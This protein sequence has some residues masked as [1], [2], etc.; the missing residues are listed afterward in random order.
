MQI[1]CRIS[2]PEHYIPKARY[3]LEMLLY[4]LGLEPAWTDDPNVDLH[5]GPDAAEGARVWLPMAGSAP[6]DFSEVRPGETPAFALDPADPACDPIATAFFWL[7]G[8]QERTCPVRDVHGRF[9]YAASIPHDP[10]LPV[11]DLIRERL[12]DQLEDAGITTARRK[13]D[14]HEWAFCPTHDVDYL[15]KRR[16]GIVFRE[17]V[18]YPL[19]GHG[20][21]RLA[22]STRQ[23]LG[24]DPYR[25]A[26]PR[27]AAEEERRGARATWF[28]KAGTHGPHDVAYRLPETLLGRLRDAGHEIGLHPSYYAH[29]HPTY[30]AGERDRLSHVLG[31]APASV[32]QHYLRYDPALTP[33]LQEASGF[34]IDSTLGWAEREGFRR[35]TCHP[36]RIFDID[37]NRPLALWEM[38]LSVMEAALFNRQHYSL[39]EAVSATRRVMDACRRFGGVC[40]VLWHNMLWDEIDAPGW[41]EHF[42]SVLDAARQSGAYLTT[43]SDALQQWG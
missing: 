17:Y 19:A 32:R 25:H 39:E 43:L 22:A 4:P 2:A 40:V 20:L 12:R 23:F 13:W 42:T 28:F 8:W 21:R 1:R 15:Y 27:M 41:A 29:T 30:L 18:Q 36:F 9:P 37:A 24:P 3:A 5:Y 34:R 7:S 33:R 26:I 31:T 38:P 35:G 10:L 11:V 16:P 6:D 14:G